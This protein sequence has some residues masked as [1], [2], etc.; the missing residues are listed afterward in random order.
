MS[1]F[2]SERETFYTFLS[3]MAIQGVFLERA[4]WR[5][6]RFSTNEFNDWNGLQWKDGIPVYTK[7]VSLRLRDK[8]Q[9]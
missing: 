6:E 2:W 7:L 4:V 8:E 3:N 1:S 5:M 9:L